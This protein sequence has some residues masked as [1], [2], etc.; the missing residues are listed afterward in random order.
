MPNISLDSPVIPLA[1][2]YLAGQSRKGRTFTGGES[3]KGM[4]AAGF[5]AS[6]SDWA[7]NQLLSAANMSGTVSNS[8]AKALIGAGISRYGDPI[9]AHRAMSRGIMYNVASEAFTELGA[10]AGSLFGSIGGGSGS[11]GVPTRTATTSV[12]PETVTRDRMGGG[13]SGTTF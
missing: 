2:L 8:L 13:A 6:S 4:L 1:G 12:Q 3:G 5:A 9:P 7:A 11:S 10:D